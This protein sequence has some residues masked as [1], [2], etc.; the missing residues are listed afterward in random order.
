MCTFAI[1]FRWILLGEKPAEEIKTQTLCSLIFFRK[2]CLFWGD[3]KKKKVFVGQATDDYVRRK[4]FS[5]RTTTTRLHTLITFNTYDCSTPTTV[6]Q[7]ASVLN[8]THAAFIISFCFIR[9][10][11]LVSRSKWNSQTESDNREPRGFRSIELPDLWTGYS[12]VNYSRVTQWCDSSRWIH[13]LLQIHLNDSAERFVRCV[14][15]LRLLLFHLPSMK[16]TPVHGQ[17]VI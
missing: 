8:Y 2:P 14:H 10:W 16:W 11:N 6:R 13:S 9:M 3:V 7:S 4:R 17:Q 5:C 12:K 1:I 15:L